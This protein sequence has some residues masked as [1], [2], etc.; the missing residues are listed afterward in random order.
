MEN[1]EINIYE[2]LRADETRQNKAWYDWFCR[3]TSLPAKTK[4]LVRYLRQIALSNKF[5]ATKTYTFFKNNC[6]CDGRLYDD[7]RICDIKT[8]DVLYT[9]IPSN[10][11]NVKLGQSEVWGAENDFKEAIVE[12]TWKEVKEFFSN[13]PVTVNA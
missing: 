6:P 5:D 11:H 8:G 9:I 4:K 2:F 13:A 12:G 7:F 10:G 3:D 1:K